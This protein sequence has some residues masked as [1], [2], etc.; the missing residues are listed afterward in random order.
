MISATPAAI[1]AWA[2]FDVGRDTMS[3]VSDAYLQKGE[4]ALPRGVLKKVI[5]NLQASGPPPG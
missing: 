1:G 2:G 4:Y 3:P 5:V